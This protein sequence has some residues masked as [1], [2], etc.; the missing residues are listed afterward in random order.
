[1]KTLYNK[2]KQKFL[3]ANLIEWGGMFIG[4][5][6]IC[7]AG[8]NMYK[9]FTFKLYFLTMAI[10]GYGWLIYS[11]I[12]LQ[13]FKWWEL[14]EAWGLGLV[15]T[16]GFTILLVLKDLKKAKNLIFLITMLSLVYGIYATGLDCISFKGNWVSED[17]RWSFFTDILRIVF[18]Y[19]ILTYLSKQENLQ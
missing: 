16:I 11:I 12:H 19:F 9:N 7:K 4:D 14:T 2:V 3:P 8:A 6:E 17:A 15:T 1:M 5:R 13:R 10:N 18:S